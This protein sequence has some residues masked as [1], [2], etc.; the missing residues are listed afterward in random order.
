MSEL[1]NAIRELFKVK[2]FKTTFEELAYDLN[3]SIEE[4]QMLRLI[5]EK[6]ELNG[7][8]YLTDS[9]E[10]I[11]F[12]KHSS[13]SIGEVRLNKQKKP[14]ILVGQSVVSISENHLNGAIRGDIVLIK[15]NNF[16]EIG[17]NLAFVEKI[18]DRKNHFIIFECY[19]DKSKKR[20]RPYNSPFKYPVSLNRKDWSTL[21]IGERFAVHVDTINHN[22]IFHG[23]VVF[24]IG[25]KDDPLLALKTIAASH[26][27]RIGFPKDV[28]EEAK[29]IPTMVSE[30]EITAETNNGRVDLRNKIIF[31]IDGK[32]T[33]DIDDAASLEINE[34]GNYVLGVHIADVAYYVKEGTAIQ[35]EASIRATSYYFGSLV[36]PML[37]PELSNG[38]CSLNPDVDRFTRTTEIEI[39]PTGEII[40]YKQYKSIIHSRKKM[41]Y[42]EINQILA[43]KRKPA[44]Y[45]EF[46]PILQNMLTLSNQLDK[47]KEQRGYINFGKDDFFITTNE[48]GK[49]KDIVLIQRGASEKIIENF[50]LLANEITAEEQ[51][52]FQVEGN[53]LPCIYRVHGKP[54]K[55]RINEIMNYL[56]HSG[57]PIEKKDYQDPKDFQQLLKS[58]SDLPAFPAIAENL[59]HGLSKAK[60]SVTNSGHYGLALFNYT[61]STSPI[62][63]YSDLQTQY[64]MDEYEKEEASIDMTS[65][66]EKMIKICRHNTKVE[67]IAEATEKEITGYQ[68]AQ[69]MENKV[70]EDFTGMIIYISKHHIVVRTPDFIV[71]SIPT[72]E[73]LSLG[74]KL[75]AQGTTLVNPNNDETL[76]IGDFLNVTLSEANLETRKIK[77]TISKSKTKNI[78]KQAHKKTS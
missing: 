56:I 19:K 75:Q 60:Y 30:E 55:Q 54:D 47:V 65:L 63:R 15:R 5:L 76:R 62:R 67:K 44:D 42:E 70:G 51:S 43:G 2:G 21:R 18:L 20:I 11:P 3:L 31:T 45:E 53:Q 57:F 52:K 4:C 74:Y 48:Q 26:G 22:G 49:P 12:P 68:F 34:Q 7:E 77:F 14:F 59:I 64:N 17:K 13:L 72:E 23:D 28:E 29:S 35:K 10:Y 73:L 58:L 71:G 61:H 36:I 41:V 39:S 6:L 46:M 33:K 8:I 25:K 37:P 66:S 50:A 78:H 32:S 16:V 24:K 27:I 69:Y 38:I 1:T 40:G 9:Q